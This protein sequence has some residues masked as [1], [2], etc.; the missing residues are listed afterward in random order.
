[1][2]VLTNAIRDYA[3]GSRTHIPRFLG[4]EPSRDP[5]AELWLGAHEGAP[6]RLPDGR[7][8]DEAIRGQAD[9]MLGPRVREMFGDRLPFLMK[10]LAADEPLSLQVHP[11]SARAQIGFAQEEAAG[12]PRDDPKRSYRDAWHKPELVYAL[13]RFEGMAGFRD[14]DKSAHLLRLLRLPW[15]DE[16]AAEL[17][18][19]SPF[20]ALR[21]VVTELLALQGDDL[22]SLMDSVATAAA[23]AEARGHRREALAR[24]REA[25]SGSIDREA[26]RVFA[27]VP[28]LVARYPSD[29]GV[30]VTLLLNHVVLAPGEALFLSAGVMHAYT[31]GLGLEIMASSD[32][33]LRAGLTVK[34]TDVPELLRV[35]NFN[36]IPKPRWDP[37]AT[38]DGTVVLEPPVDEFALSVGPPGLA[39]PDS[40]PRIVLVLDGVV[41]LN[42]NAGRLRVERG[43]AVFVPHDEGRVEVAGRGRVAVGAVPS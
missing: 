22:T 25:R 28:G 12:I 21:R 5:A 23:H 34:H 20:Q 33:V 14:V 19:G 29:P 6:S 8:L 1:M 4:R 2:F 7:Y 37:T 10:V 13:T 3:W 42:S 16:V 27:L 11:S 30:L 15:A 26:I 38:T 32:N 17:E 40:G 36:P 39:L 18:V 24:P 9:S 35:A 43:E 31:S 41:E